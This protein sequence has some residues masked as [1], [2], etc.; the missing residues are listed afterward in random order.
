M[1]DRSDQIISPYVARASSFSRGFYS[2]PASYTGTRELHKLNMFYWLELSEVY[3]SSAHILKARQMSYYTWCKLD[4]LAHGLS[5][6]RI[7]YFE[8]VV[9]SF[10]VFMLLLILIVCTTVGYCGTTNSS[11]KTTVGIPCEQ[12]VIIV[13]TY[14]VYHTLFVFLVCRPPFSVATRLQYM[15]SLLH[16]SIPSAVPS[17]VPGLVSGTG[18]NIKPALKQGPSTTVANNRRAPLPSNKI[19]RAQ[20]ATHPSYVPQ[21]S[22]SYHRRRGK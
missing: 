14:I 5:W 6:V 13:R 21:H 18:I 15:W 11:M 2:L 17:D 12:G 16:W 20:R 19:F 4:E 3:S 22:S 8:L 9:T 10:A 1:Y 7:A